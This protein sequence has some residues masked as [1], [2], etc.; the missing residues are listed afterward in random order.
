M[1]VFLGIPP[2][3]ICGICGKLRSG[4]ALKPYGQLREKVIGVIGTFLCQPYR[5]K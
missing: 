3:G 4:A 2:A 1:T 5:K